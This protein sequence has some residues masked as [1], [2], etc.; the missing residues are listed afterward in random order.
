M[1][2]SKLWSLGI[3]SL[4]QTLDGNPLN[5]ILY[6]LYTPWCNDLRKISSENVHMSKMISRYESMWL[7][8][9]TAG[10]EI[11]F[12]L[13]PK[14]KPI[15]KS[16]QKQSCA[17]ILLISPLITSNRLFNMTFHCLRSQTNGID[18]LQR[19]DLYKC[20]YNVYIECNRC[21]FWWMIVMILI[22]PY[23]IRPI[24]IEMNDLVVQNHFY[25]SNTSEWIFH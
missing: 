8:P 4:V 25:H 17:W 14:S 16:K 18:N 22:K 20:E 11:N 3:A 19:D 13:L 2:V 23:Y 12:K 9:I 24:H 15:N 5:V 6:N 21:F 1:S 10:Y 7:D